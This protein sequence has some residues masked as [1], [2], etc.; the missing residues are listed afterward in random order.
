MVVCWQINP[1]WLFTPQI[2]Y[3][4]GNLYSKNYCHQSKLGASLCHFHKGDVLVK[5]G[6]KSYPVEN[7]ILWHHARQSIREGHGTKDGCSHHRPPQESRMLLEQ[8]LVLFSS[9]TNY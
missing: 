2:L 7:S 9:I 6:E 4:V 3:V 1:K 5:G 8:V